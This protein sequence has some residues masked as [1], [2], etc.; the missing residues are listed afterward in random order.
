MISCVRG[1]DLQRR[2]AARS[3][4]VFLGVLTRRARA[5][6]ELHLQASIFLAAALVPLS[7]ETPAMTTGLAG[8]T[9]V[10]GV[11]VSLDSGDKWLACGDKACRCIEAP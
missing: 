10:R 3:P 11:C 5:A 1:R 9:S 4:K 8:V 7:V 2:K 6:K